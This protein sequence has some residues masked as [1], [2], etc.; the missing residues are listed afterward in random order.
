[1]DKFRLFNVVD[2]SVY[3]KNH[4]IRIP[5]CIKINGSVPEYR[6]FDIIFGSF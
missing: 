3:S 5:G 4:N 1:M 6:R 2:L